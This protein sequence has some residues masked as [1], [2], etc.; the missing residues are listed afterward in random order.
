MNANREQQQPRRQGFDAPEDP[1]LPPEVPIPHFETPADPEAMASFKYLSAVRKELYANTPKFRG[2]KFD[3]WTGWKQSWRDAIRSAMH[4]TSDEEGRKLSIIQALEGEGKDQASHVTARS[5]FLSSIE[6]L[7]LLDATFLPKSQSNAAKN[8][9]EAYVQQPTQDVMSYLSNKQ[10]LFDQGW[11]G[12][13]DKAY[14]RKRMLEGVC[15]V[16]VKRNLMRKTYH[17]TAQLRDAIVNECSSQKE[18]I[19]Q[20]IA[21]DTTMDGLY[22]SNDPINRR[23]ASTTTVAAAQPMFAVMPQSQMTNHQQP[24]YQMQSQLPAQ[25]QTQW[26]YQVQQPFQ[27]P[28]Y[29][30][31]AMPA[32]TMSCYGCGQPGHMVR[33]CPQQ[34]TN[35]YQPRPPANCGRTRGNGRNSQPNSRFQPTCYRCLQLGHLTKDCQTPEHTVDNIRKKNLERYYPKP[36]GTQNAVQ[37]TQE[38]NQEQPAASDQIGSYQ[39]AWQE[40]SSQ[41]GFR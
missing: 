3:N 7:A 30:I 26:P 16:T 27:Q 13:Q 18:M 39:Q 2:N 12:F 19:R 20:G 22:S 23:P 34:K 9:F 28:Q 24:Q 5:E 4:P 11:P 25:G 40:M 31:Q 37:S 14:L 10:R 36:L 8:E 41:A 35:G 1:D 29:A 15:N 32:A 17:D 33:D 6:I 38:S 21:L